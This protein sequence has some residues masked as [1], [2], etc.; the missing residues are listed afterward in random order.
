MSMRLIGEIGSLPI[1]SITHFGEYM[2]ITQSIVAIPLDDIFSDNEFNCR[3]IINP[4]SV[5]DLAQA[6]AKDGLLSPIIVQPWSKEA[7]F[8]W[9]IVCGHR[10]FLAYRVNRQKGLPNSDKIDCIVRNKLTEDQAYI[11]N[12][13]ENVKRADLNI[14]QEANAIKRFFLLGW[15][16][17]R[18][19]EELRVLKPWVQVRVALLT[20]P[21]EI[22]KRAEAGI[23]TQYQIQEIASMSTKEEQLAACRAAVDWKLKGNRGSLKL[24]IRQSKVLKERSVFETGQARSRQDIGIMQAAIQDALNDDH[25]LAR[26]LGWAAGFV[27]SYDLAKDI[28]A[29]ASAKGKNFFLPGETKYGKGTSV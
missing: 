11:L 22:Q 10:R 9:R 21:E 19:A 27:S 1:V 7:N 20:L 5:Q 18:I 2:D 25:I 23:L 17:Q 24:K 13:S 6:I 4:V 29:L 12:L 14:M 8:K 15:N 16:L 3:G 28:Q 26:G